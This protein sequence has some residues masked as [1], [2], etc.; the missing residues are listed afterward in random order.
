MDRKTLFQ[1]AK[2]FGLYYGTGKTEE[3]SR[4]D[5]A[6][7]E[8]LGQNA[9]SIDEL[10]SNKTLVFGYISIMEISAGSKEFFLLSDRDFL[11]INGQVIKNTDYST[12]LLDLTCE[13]WKRLLIHNIGRLFVQS[14]YD[15]VFLDT[16]GNVESAAFPPAV[17]ASQLSAAAGIVTEIRKNYP[18]HLIIQN[19]GLEKLCLLTSRLIDGICWENPPIGLPKSQSWMDAVGGRLNE[20]KN[21]S[22]LKT[23][24]LI[25]ENHASGLDNDKVLEFSKKNGY[26]TYFAP[27]RY[28]SKVNNPV[29]T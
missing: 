27:Y 8:P 16:I 24:V 20:L 1:K 26:L 12:F 11:N 2:N 7:V 10:R 22:G 28:I 4:F 17:A 3:L 15:G 9:S 23:L 14:G 5:I 13:K 21:A 25:E 18:G 29:N 19:N 6:I